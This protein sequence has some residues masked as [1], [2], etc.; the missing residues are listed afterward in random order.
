MFSGS[1]SSHGN[2]EHAFHHEGQETRASKRS[3]NMKHTRGKQYAANVAADQITRSQRG[4]WPRVTLAI[5]SVA[6][7]ALAS[8]CATKT[9]TA[10]TSS[11]PP[12]TAYAATPA[13][14]SASTP[15]GTTTGYATSSTVIT[16]QTAPQYAGR[17]VTFHQVIVHRVDGDLVFDVTAQDGSPLYF[18]LPRPNLVREGDVV[19]V[20][21]TIKERGATVITHSGLES[22]GAIVLNQQPY[23]VDVQRIETSR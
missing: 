8:G 7:L 9:E 13:V 12:A 22:Q 18:L 6:G 19:N 10:S 20:T 1:A 5:A 11:P 16:T 2:S 17:Q 14:G 23:Y 4:L 21:G 3:S 15:G